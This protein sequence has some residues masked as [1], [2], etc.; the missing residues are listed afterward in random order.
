MRRFDIFLLHL[1]AKIILIKHSNRDVTG[2][3][4]SLKLAE[5]LYLHTD[6]LMIFIAE[7]KLHVA[8]S[9]RGS[10]KEN[11]TISEPYIRTVFSPYLTTK[12]Y[13]VGTQKNHLIEI[14][15]TVLL[16]TQNAC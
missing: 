15:Q 10:F 2:N 8:L 9:D 13:V 6:K 7:K 4:Q 3:I 1:N 11:T 14:I 5:F 16:S 12:T